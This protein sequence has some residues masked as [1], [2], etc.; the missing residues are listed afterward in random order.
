MSIKDYEML[1]KLG[2]GSFGIVHKARDK[3]TN[4]IVVIKIVNISNMNA[5]LR[6]NVS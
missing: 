5:K 6:K 3:K 2:E 1:T 4:T